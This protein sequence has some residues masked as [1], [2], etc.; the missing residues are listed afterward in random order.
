MD[1]GIAWA[2]RGLAVKVRSSMPTVHLI[3]GPMGAGKTTYAIALAR[4]AHA[5]RFSLEEWLG[6]L[7]PV[8]DAAAR[9]P[10]TTQARAARCESQIWATAAQLLA[11]GCDVVLDIGLARRDHRDEAR[12]RAAR[13]GGVAKLH[14]LDVARETRSARLLARIARVEREEGPAASGQAEERQSAFEAMEAYFEPPSDDELYS[15]MIV[16][17]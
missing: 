11:I 16:C 10:A 1:F 6:T 9:D 15:A 4:R 17:E 8:D 7:F 12:L 5:V 3:C 13:V 14:Y 2:H